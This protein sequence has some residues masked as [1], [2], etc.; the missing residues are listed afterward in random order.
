[1]SNI[2]G[3]ALSHSDRRIVDS[4][5][6]ALGSSRVTCDALEHMAKTDKRVEAYLKR[7]VRGLIRKYE[8][9]GNHGRDFDKCVGYRVLCRLEGCVEGF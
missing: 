8:S 6:Y 3:N 4:L 2:G 1:M 7:R 9:R 5:V